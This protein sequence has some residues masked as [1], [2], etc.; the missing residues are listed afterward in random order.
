MAEDVAAVREHLGRHDQALDAGRHEFSRLREDVVQIGKRVSDLEPKK[1]DYLRIG[2]FVLTLVIA[3]LAGWWKLSDLFN[4]R[5]TRDELARE[6]A[7]QKVQLEQQSDDIRTI[8]DQQIEQAS[9]LKQLKASADKTNQRL[10]QLF[11]VRT[12]TSTTP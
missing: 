12:G 8:R 7:E 4:A 11:G 9:D 10:D 2:A 6:R 1:P 3:V 5:P